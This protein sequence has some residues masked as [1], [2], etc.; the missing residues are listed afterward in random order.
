M[1]GDKI[2]ELA[3]RVISS[4]QQTWSKVPDAAGTA[5]G[6][7]NLIGEHTDYT[8]GFVLP[9]AIDRHIVFAAA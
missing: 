6:R 2:T 5:P 4:F 7:I 1:R 3:T 8:G 9:V